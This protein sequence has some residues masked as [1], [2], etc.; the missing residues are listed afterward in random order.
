MNK[1]NITSLSAIEE[2][3]EEHGEPAWMHLGCRLANGWCMDIAKIAGSVVPRRGSP[4]LR[5]LSVPQKSTRQMHQV[6][7]KSYNM[8]A[9]TT[10]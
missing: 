5:S 10:V 9:F 3:L 4:K 1:C 7:R 6:A 2:Q 8:V